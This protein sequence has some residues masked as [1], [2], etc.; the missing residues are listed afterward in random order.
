MRRD[1]P[2]DLAQQR[3][4]AGRGGEQFR[5]VGEDLP[6]RVVRP[7]VEHRPVT[8]P[9]SATG[10]VNEQVVDV[11]LAVGPHPVHRAARHP[12]PLDDLFEA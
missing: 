7:G 8:E 11:V 6:D 10:Q 12:G 4:A 9:A 3:A 1:D 2:D 5:V